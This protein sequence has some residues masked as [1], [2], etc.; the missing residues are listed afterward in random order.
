MNQDFGPMSYNSGVCKCVF[1][2]LIYSI[3]LLFRIFQAVS[4]YPGTGQIYAVDMEGKLWVGDS[5][6]G[7]FVEDT[8]LPE[9]SVLPDLLM[10][11]F[12]TDSHLKRSNTV[13]DCCLSVYF[14]NFVIFVFSLGYVTKFSS[15]NVFTLYLNLFLGLH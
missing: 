9:K 4:A 2:T 6:L 13:H 8:S 12:I 15:S 1:D 5:F 14:H 7:P 11:R 10:N 3:C